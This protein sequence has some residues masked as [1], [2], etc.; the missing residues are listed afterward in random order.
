ML[1]VTWWQ[2]DK[3]ST[4]TFLLHTFILHRTYFFNGW[5]VFIQTK[6]LF[7][8]KQCSISHSLGST[9]NRIK[10]CNRILQCTLNCWWPLIIKR[11][12][13]HHVC[14]IPADTRKIL[15][16][17]HCLYGATQH[18]GQLLVMHIL[19]LLHLQ[20]QCLERKFTVLQLL[21]HTFYYWR[22]AL[23]K[24]WEAYFC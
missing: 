17:K 13:S 22:I 24:L 21:L 8:D 3:C 7:W 18:S 12:P 14:L 11:N 23:I 9:A 15:F 19:K 6:Y 5:K 20:K 10:I 16:A 4:I 2:H 1:Q